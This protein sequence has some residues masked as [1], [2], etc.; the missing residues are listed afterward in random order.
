MTVNIVKWRVNFNCGCTFTTQKTEE[1]ISHAR[2]TGHTIHAVGT[3]G[4]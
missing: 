4:K 3:V 2:E 1:A